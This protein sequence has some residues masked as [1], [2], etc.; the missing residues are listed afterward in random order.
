MHSDNTKDRLLTR[1]LCLAMPLLLLAPLAGCRKH[2]KYR[3]GVSQ[4]SLDDWREKLN[5]EIEREMIFHPEAEV[6][7]RSSDDNPEKQRS[8][9]RYFADNGFDIIIASPVESKALVGA[10]DSAVAKG[11]PVLTFDREVDSDKQ[12]AHIGADN[13][14]IGRSMG[15]Y[16][17]RRMTH[18][19]KVAEIGG[20]KSSSPAKDRHQGFVDALSAYP[21]LSLVAT[22][23]GDWTPASG[24]RLAD[25]L[26]AA[27][28]D[29]DALVV[30][31]DRMAIA[32]R[33]VARARG[34]DNLY[35]S[36]V[37]AVPATG[38]KAVAD[39]DLDVTFYYP[40]AGYEIMRKAFRILNGEDYNKELVLASATSVDS[41]NVEMIQVQEATMQEDTHKILS[42][43]DKVDDYTTLHAQQRALLISFVIILLLSVV[44]IFFLLRT[45]WARRRSQAELAFQY[46]KLSKQRDMLEQ[47]K[48]ELTAQKQEL[49]EQRDK[50]AELNDRLTTATTAKLAFF[51]NVSHDLRTPLTLIAEPLRQLEGC[52]QLTPQQQTLVALADKNVKILMRLINQILDFRK[53]ENGKM[54]LHLSEVDPAAGLQGWVEAFEPL[55]LK[56]HIHLKLVS[57]WPAHQTLAL[58]T[59]KMERV[60]FNIMSNAFKFTPGNGSI[61]VTLSLE[62]N[63]MVIKVADT[64]R[65][66]SEEDMKRVFERFFQAE[67]V[68]PGGSG[69]GLTVSKAFAVMHG[70]DILVKSKPGEGSEFTIV[71]PVTHVEADVQ[72]AESLASISDKEIIA[73][74][75]DP[76]EECNVE[77]GDG[78]CVLVIDD[79]AD[80]RLMLKQLLQ[81]RYTVLEAPDGQLGIKMATRYLP[82]AIV[83]DVMMP[84][85][86]GMEVCRSLKRETATSHIPIL[87][88]TA[89]AL[90]EQRVEGYEQGAD[91]YLSKPF[92]GDVLRARIKS[93]IANRRLLSDIHADPHAPAKS[94]PALPKADPAKAKSGDLDTDFYRQFTQIVEREL[95]NSALTTEIVADEMGFSRTQLYRKLKALTN[96][97]PNELIRNMRLKRARQLLAQTEDTVSQIAYAVGF[98]SPSYFSKCFKDY[99]GELPADVQRRTSKPQ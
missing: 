11:V 44:F 30:H 34:M 5:Q 31:N 70:G 10:I 49:T 58:D 41:A 90:D 47:Q 92:S 91:G 53:Y 86:D 48:G 39:G 71:I 84:G 3:I 79:N 15:D 95:P 80:I 68:R 63:N 57:H 18:P 55:A 28:P 46:D 74:L 42:L 36:G 17:G 1:I 98:N 2:T 75:G 4:C 16:L 45:Y 73:E 81:D 60:F 13:R 27:H 9:I 61:N 54:E 93:L 99:F 64:G 69:I 12:T 38:I 6:E 40:T 26:L 25:S 20:L 96:Y 85:M 29:L 23:Y 19:A 32:A 59:E 88:L 89:C 8:D 67:T 82:D 52:S 76:E 33:K 66:L 7:I 97:S 83:C 56:R 62:D 21:N 87:M 50:M 51:T 37:D 22:A 43:K 72:A 94:A 77:L 78:P 65:G 35:I 14:M 24:E